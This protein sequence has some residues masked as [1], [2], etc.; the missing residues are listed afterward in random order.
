[1]ESMTFDQILTLAAQLTPDEQAALV[2]RL[3]A[4]SNPEWC[5]LIDQMAGGPADDPM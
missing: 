4:A 1:M 3:H 5:L 2:D